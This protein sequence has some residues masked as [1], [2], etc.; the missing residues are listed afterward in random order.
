[1]APVS[2]GIPMRLFEYLRQRFWSTDFFTRMGQM[3]AQLRRRWRVR[4]NSRKRKEPV[5][6]T[7]E[8]MEP[9]LVPSG[10][11]FT[12]NSAGNWESA[13]VWTRTGAGSGGETTPQ[14]GDNVV[15]QNAVTV[16]TS[17][18]AAS[19]ETAQSLTVSG[20]TLSF[21]SG[22]TLTLSSGTATFSGG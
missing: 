13:A 2:G 21:L 9:R 1:M 14:S 6:T 19:N 3:M 16:A 17:G 10:Y 4:H 5:R 22:S 12:S 8:S 20:G 18:G 11:T 15:V 7:F